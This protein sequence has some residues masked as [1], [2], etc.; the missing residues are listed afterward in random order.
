MKLRYS[1]Y[2]LALWCAFQSGQAYKAY[3]LEAAYQPGL[4]VMT[5]DAARAYPAY[6]AEQ[7][8]EATRII[9]EYFTPED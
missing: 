4:P 2:A 3:A 5:E 6:D 8:A 9:H 7:Y 1:F